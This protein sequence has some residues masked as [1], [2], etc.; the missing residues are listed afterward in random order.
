VIPKVRQVGGLVGAAVL[1]GAG[2]IPLGAQ[3]QVPGNDWEKAD[4][5]A[6]GLDV[7]AIEAHRALC[8][9]SGADACLVAY[10]GRIVSEWYGPRYAQPMYTMSSVKSWTGLLTGMLIAD[11]KIKGVEEPVSVFLPEWR[12][13]PKA[14]V[15]VRHLLTMTS[16]LKQRLGRETGPDQSV[17]FASD[18]NAFVVG[19]PLSFAPGERWSYSN[20]GAQLLSP[21][22]E[23][24][25]G[26]PIQDYARTRLFEPLGMTQTRLNLDQKGHA[27]TYADAQTSLRD[28]AKIGQLMLQRGKWGDRQIVP[29][30]WVRDSTRTCPQNPRYGYLWWLFDDPKGF[31][32]LGYRD[33]NCY[34]FPDLDLVVARIQNA[35]SQDGAARYEPAALPLFRRMGKPK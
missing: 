8:E 26:V 24:A 12:E 25:A 17:G 35:P 1:L 10:N 16:G 11:G 15:T 13:G 9:R 20:E 30:S 34:V 18:K 31:A 22:L 28:F 6:V 2:L 19:L 14:K 21:L 5:K 32:S 33:T 29:E 23:A 3:A 27:W 4:A 7:E